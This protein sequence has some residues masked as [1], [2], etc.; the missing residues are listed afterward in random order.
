MI[1]AVYR[2]EIVARYDCEDCRRSAMEWTR[3]G[4]CTGPLPDDQQATLPIML[5]DKHGL[6]A[7]SG[8]EFPARFDTC[9]RGLLRHDLDRDGE[10]LAARVVS[11]AVVAEI[12]ERW[13]DVPARLY[14][15]AQL[16]RQTAD[17]RR[18]AQWA[19]DREVVR[20]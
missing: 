7:A 1:A 17:E 18:E 3:L 15:L 13:P 10:L 6:E 8:K 4:R 16:W 11:Q 19:A 2:D 5:R 9:P 20:R 12:H 14:R